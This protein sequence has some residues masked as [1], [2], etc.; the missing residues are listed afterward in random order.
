MHTQLLLMIDPKG[1]RERFPPRSLTFKHFQMHF[2]IIQIAC[3]PQNDQQVQTQNC[4]KNFSY[5]YLFLFNRI[6][7]FSQRKFLFRNQNPWKA[8]KYFKKWA[9][10]PAIKDGHVE[11][12][13]YFQKSDFQQ[14][15]FF[16]MINPFFSFKFDKQQA[17]T[18][19]VI[20]SHSVRSIQ[21]HQN[22]TQIFQRFQILPKMLLVLQ[23]FHFVTL[24]S[25]DFKLYNYG[26]QKDQT[27]QMTLGDKMQIMMIMLTD[28]S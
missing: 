27:N 17:N 25:Q 9:S 1:P 19:H 20:L 10:N 26:K 23:I 18:Q 21:I 28:T 3:T 15:F 14:E 16:Q 4:A 11:E 12:H 6:I 7:N 22:P 2:L 24:V 13:P 8:S 5:V